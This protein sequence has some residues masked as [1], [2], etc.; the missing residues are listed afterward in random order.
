M[1]LAGCE[2]APAQGVDAIEQGQAHHLAASL[3]VSLALFGLLAAAESA[4]FNP[5]GAVLVGAILY[6]VVIT[7]LS[8][9]AALAMLLPAFVTLPF[10]ALIGVALILGGI[11]N[12][13]YAL[14]IAYT[15][16]FLGR[17]Q[18]AAASAGLIFLNGVGATGQIPSHPG[19]KAP[20]IQ[21]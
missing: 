3:A 9:V 1:R 6:L 5:V 17:D 7:G 19:I 16:D 10:P 14:L 8:A 15:N 11:S 13:I 21:M 12:P 2:Q 4:E 18:M 20:L